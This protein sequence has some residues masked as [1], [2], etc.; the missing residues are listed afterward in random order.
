MTHSISIIVPAHEDGEFLRRCL[1]GI[2]SMSPQA[3]EVILVEDGAGDSTRSLARKFGYRWL[4]NPSGRGPARARN[5]GASHAE[6]DLLFFIDSDVI[7]R[8]DASAQVQRVFT[9]DPELRAVIGSYDDE[10]AAGNFTSQYKNLFHHYIHQHSEEAASTFWGACG[11]IDRKVFLDIGGFDEHY[12]RPCIEDIEFGSRLTRAGFRIRLCKALQCKHL[13]RWSFASLL[14]TDLLDRA[15]PWTE[16]ILRDHKLINDLNLR[17]SSRISVVLLFAS[18]GLLAAGFWKL[19]SAA[20]GLILLLA[21]LAINLPVYQFF[22]AKRG[23]WF[24]IK[25]V[26]WHCIYY[27]CCGLGF[28]LGLGRAQLHRAR[29]FL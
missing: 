6:G 11:A 18:L 28:A 8:P 22:F 27:L 13:K 1:A 2:A 7:V 23:L 19:E 17:P 10:P 3:A 12:R 26:L 24:M 29:I 15:V 14:K 5:L 21:V 9:D 4:N 25:A 16:L 20:I